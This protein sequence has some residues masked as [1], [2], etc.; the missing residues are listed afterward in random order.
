MHILLV[1]NMQGRHAKGAGD[2]SGA[3]LSGWK[4][5]DA[6]AIDHVIGHTIGHTFGHA[7]GWMYPS[8]FSS[9]AISTAPPAAPRTVLWE[10]LTNL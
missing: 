7:F 8:A 9:S 5:L 10:R 3:F 6:A 2:R 4:P 1:G